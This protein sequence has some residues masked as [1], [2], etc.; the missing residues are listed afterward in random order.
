M[1]TQHE[2]A[3]ASTTR[4][5]HEEDDDQRIAFTNS[6]NYI[7]NKE[8]K[9]LVRVENKKVQASEITPLQDLIAGGVSGTA[10]VIV[11]HPFDTFKVRLQL[12]G[13]TGGFSSLFKGMAAPASMAA[14]INAVIFSSFGWSSRIWDTSP[15]LEP[16]SGY[17]NF[18]CGSFSGLVQCLIVCPVVSFYFFTL[19]I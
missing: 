8:E 9:N 3:D 19:F 17:K 16:Y 18:V 7:R 1:T 15:A 10:C 2:L 4:I 14:A 13:T 5:G 11:G 12:G 6:S